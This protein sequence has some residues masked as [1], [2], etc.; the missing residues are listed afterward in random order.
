MIQQVE[1]IGGTESK[2]M[3]SSYEIFVP[4]ENN[5]AL[6]KTHPGYCMIH[7]NEPSDCPGGS[8]CSFKRNQFKSHAD[9]TPDQGGLLI[10]SGSDPNAHQSLFTC[11]QRCLYL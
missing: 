6:V 8:R 1:V 7:R 4:A 5:K 2:Q 9:V 3:H 11:L 10:L